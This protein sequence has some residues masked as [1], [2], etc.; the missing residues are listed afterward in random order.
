MV[1]MITSFF[2]RESWPRHRVALAALLVIHTALLVHLG[3][4]NAPTIDEPGHLVGGISHWQYANFDLYQVNPPLVRLVAALP[5]LAT[6]QKTDWSNFRA[7]QARGE[8]ATG[9]AYMTGNG[10]RAFWYL[11]LARWACIPFSLL[12]LLICYAFGRDLYGRAAGLFAA[13]LWC[14]SPN[15]LANASLITP[16]AGA[17]ATGI[18]AVYFFWRWLRQPDWFRVLIAGL[19][20]GLCLSTKF[21]WIILIPVF[22]LLWLFWRITAPRGQ[23][24]RGVLW[25]LAQQVAA[26]AVCLYVINSIYA[27]QETCLPFKEIS[28][29]SK[30][31]EEVLAPRQ[32]TC[33]GDIPVPL[34]RR[35]PEGI[36]LQK[37]ANEGGGANNYLLG[38]Y[39]DVGW[40]YYYLYGMLIK[41]PIGTLALIVLALLYAFLGGFRSWRKRRAARRSAKPAEQ[42]QFMPNE[43]TAPATSAAVTSPEEI[44]GHD[45]GWR[46]V[47][48]MLTPGVLLLAVVS[49]QTE[50]N[51]HL[52]YVLPAFPFLFVWAGS[53]AAPFTLRRSETGFWRSILALGLLLSAVCSAMYRYPHPQSYFNELI[54][55][56]VNAHYHLLNS[57]LDWG[58]EGFALEE[59]VKS[60]EADG[61]VYIAYFGLAS[62][63][64]IMEIDD[65]HWAKRSQATD[66]SSLPPGWYAVSAERLHA[67]TPESQDTGLPSLLKRTPDGM[68][69]YSIYIYHV[70]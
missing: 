48:I 19:T 21:T 33:L 61:P 16:D 26:A 49:S 12:G 13:T 36:D 47:V 22:P 27:F 66:A 4:R 18:M 64:K 5:L 3:W 32:K 1:R 44:V 25:Q 45:T 11:T 20:F 42:K 54:G 59:F 58:Q 2:R 46:D 57:N 24:L 65:S 69:G 60:H 62:T 50:I 40:W 6:D 51:R 53:L 17:A 43:V 38:E 37:R 29:T 14:F 28:F 23:K 39:R 8:Y 9:E 52:R 7:G 30:T 67:R 63:V 68:I 70:E 41:M 35:F 10:R 56:P 34:P 31:G 55:G 15:V